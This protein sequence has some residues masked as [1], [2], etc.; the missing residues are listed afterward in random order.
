MRRFVFP[1][2]VA[3]GLVVIGAGPASAERAPTATAATAVPGKKICKVTDPKL[4]ELSGIVATGSGFVVID[5]STTLS[6]HKRIFYLDA[7]CAI[8]KSVRYSGNGPRDTEDMIVTPNGKTLWIA[9]TGDNDRSRSTVS[10]WSMPVDGSES[11]EIH[12]LAYPDGRHDAEALLLD[13]DGTPVIVTKEVGRPASIYTPTGPLKTNNLTGVPLEKAGEI[14]VPESDTSANAVARIGRASIDGGAIAPGGGR[15]VLRTYTDALEWTVSGGD[16]LAALKGKPRVTPL[17][18]EPLGEAITY[19]PDGKYFYTVS[20]MQGQ[21]P[22]GENYILRYAPASSTVTK[23]AAGAEKASAAGPSWFSRLTLDDI[24]RIVIGIGVLG[25]ILVGLGVFGI[26]RSRRHP[27]AGPSGRDGSKPGDAL[28]ELAGL[29]PDLRSQQGLGSPQRPGSQQRPGV[30][31]GAQAGPGLGAGSAGRGG[32]AGTAGRG[33]PGAAG[34]GAAGSGGVYGSRSGSAPTRSGSIPQRGGGGGVYG[35]APSG[36][37]GGD[38]SRGDRSGAGRPGA[39]RSGADR[40]DG[41]GG[42]GGSSSGRPGY[43]GDGSPPGD[44]NGGGQQGGRPGY[45]D[46]GGRPGSGGRSGQGGQSGRGG[47]GSPPPERNASARPQPHLSGAYAPAPY[48]DVNV[49]RRG[50]DYDNPDYGRSPYGR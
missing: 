11:P 20:D 40:S 28:T 41:R 14:T 1:I 33:G 48:A 23:A 35:G 26:V 5:D 50:R 4:N 19:S 37:R 45:G 18:D 10:L 12:R 13:G 34:P 15:V 30:Y 7:Q 16:V 47:Y 36:G 24:T 22:S 44:R 6:D 27:P 31:G 21:T 29:P 32:P 25:V 43:R 39:D 42:S 38:P 8:V 9:D 3:A 46:Q 49:A 2:I 17:P